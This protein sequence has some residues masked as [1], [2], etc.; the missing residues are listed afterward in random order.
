MK[1]AVRGGYGLE[2][3]KQQVPVKSLQGD[4]SHV[5][6]TFLLFFFGPLIAAVPSCRR[7]PRRELPAWPNQPAATLLIPYFEVDLGDPA[8]ADHP[9]LGQQRLGQVGARPRGAVDRLGGPDPGLRRLPDRLRRADH[10]PARPL[11]GNLPRP[12][13]TAQQLGHAL[14]PNGDPLRRLRQHRRGRRLAGSSAAA[15]APGS[16]PPTPAS[17]WRHRPRRSCAGSA[18]ADPTSRPATSPSTR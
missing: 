8:G 14:G 5:R 15:S 4:N 17:R 18:S 7:R 10:Q 3:S 9:V 13:R 11:P 1:V 2:T 16:A 12:G 6:E